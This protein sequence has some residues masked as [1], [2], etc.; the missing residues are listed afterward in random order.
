MWIKE[1]ENNKIILWQGKEKELAS[2]L[3]SNPKKVH[4]KFTEKFIEYSACNI[5]LQIKTFSEHF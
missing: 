4:R 3:K 5:L 1:K 2:Q